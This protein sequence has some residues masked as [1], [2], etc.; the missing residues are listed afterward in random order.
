[1]ALIIN[2][3][4]VSLNAQRHL[5]R[6]TMA[7]GKSL[8]K[9]AS[10]YRINRAGDDAAGMQISEILRGQIRG[11][12]KA[13]ENTQAGQNVLQ[14]ADGSMEMIT[15]NLQRIRELTVQAA[16]DTNGA[17]QRTAIE[18]EIDARR[19][20]IDRIA[21]ASQFNGRVLLDGS[22]AAANSFVLQVGPNAAANADVIDI[23]S[24][25]DDAQVANL[26]LTAATG[27]FLS[28]ATIQT[29][30]GLVDTAMD[31]INTQRAT[32]GSFMNRL[33]SAI[34]NLQNSIENQSA[35]ESQIRNV[36]VAAESATMTRNQILQQASNTILAQAN[37]SP[38]LALQLLK[39]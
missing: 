35:A 20:D 31:T 36:D 13:L 32:I 6:N 3:N 29:Y 39:G 10:G 1:M 27:T 21:N 23:S 25:F 7:L 11:S 24:A 14:I 15:E 33:D 8:E 38:Q 18:Q 5:S 22:N 4:T 37:Q 30:L 34:N 17:N 19:A 9:L 2:T 16:N 26:G 12:Q 28:N